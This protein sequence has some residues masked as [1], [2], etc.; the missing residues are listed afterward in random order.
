MNFTTI[1]QISFPIGGRC[2]CVVT[3]LSNLIAEYYRKRDKIPR[4]RFKSNVS[5]KHSITLCRYMR[6][7]KIENDKNAVRNAFSPRCT[8]ICYM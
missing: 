8:A 6:I 3:D 4:Y 5:V 2:L 7:N 1:V